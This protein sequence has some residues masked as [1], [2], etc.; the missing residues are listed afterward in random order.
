MGWSED[1]AYICYWQKYPAHLQQ[2]SLCDTDWFEGALQIWL[3]YENFMKWLVSLPS[4]HIP[5]FCHVK[6]HLDVEYSPVHL[7]LWMKTYPVSIK[8]ADHIIQSLWELH[9]LEFPLFVQKYDRQQYQIQTF[10]LP[11]KIIVCIG[12]W[13][14]FRT[15]C[16]LV[17][18]T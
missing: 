13:L 4:S 14:R 17:D 9:H 12:S 7:Y 3:C 11:L 6:C 1:A 16:L 8:Q 10:Y 2:T 5:H 18:T 15:T